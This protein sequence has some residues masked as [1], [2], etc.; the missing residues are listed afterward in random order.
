M[1]VPT[2]KPAV[3]NFDYSQQIREGGLNGRQALI[4]FMIGLLVLFDG[5]DNQ[6]I[7]LIAHDISLDLNVPISAFGIVFS[8]SLIGAIVGALLLSAAADQWLGRKRV[9]ITAMALAGVCTVL[10][11]HADTLP[12]LIFIRFL[13]GIGLGA[14]LPNAISLASEFSPKR[15]SRLVVSIMVACV[16]LGSLLGSVMA[17]GILPTFDWQTLLYVAGIGTLILIASA[18]FIVPESVHFLL[19]KDAGQRRAISAVKKLFPVS[20]ITSVTAD[21]DSAEASKTRKQPVASLFSADLWKLTLLFWLAFIMDQ[22]ILYFVMNWTPALLLKSGMS[23]TS[24]MDAAAMFGLGGAIGTVAQGWLTTRF[25]IYKVM[26]IEIVIYSSAMLMMPLV[27]GDAF[28]APILVF[29]VAATI[30]AY[31]AGLI[32]LILESF[33]EAIK[34][35]AFGWA[36]GIGRIGATG[37]PVL[38]GFLLGIGW[39]PAFLFIGAAIPGILTGLA[40][41]GVRHVLAKQS[42][43]EKRAEPGVLKTV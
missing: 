13:T 32:T 4:L 21:A 15:H 9:V 11:A 18:A 40:L 23:S 27:L 34:A 10:T 6:L 1:S 38:A 42:G 17:R 22:A 8:S 7:G 3:S 35:T 43:N 30:C 37:A 36:F 41:I 31:H 39:S 28:V 14:A 24:G 12:Q 26:L 29:I 16:P 20:G 19:R 5:M 2:S 25:G 33:P